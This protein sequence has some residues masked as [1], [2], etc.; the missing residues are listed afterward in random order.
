LA[1]EDPEGDNSRA[2]VTEPHRLERP[3]FRDH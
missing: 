2:S 3:F 1:G